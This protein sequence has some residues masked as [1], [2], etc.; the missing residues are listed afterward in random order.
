MNYPPARSLRLDDRRGKEAAKK[1]AETQVFDRRVKNYQ[2]KVHRCWAPEQ[3]SIM[4]N[5]SFQKSNPPFLVQI[6]SECQK[7]RNR[8]GILGRTKVFE[9]TRH[10]DG[11]HRG[12]FSH[13]ILFLILFTILFTHWDCFGV[14]CSVFLGFYVGL[15]HLHDYDYYS[16]RRLTQDICKH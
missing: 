9:V 12:F 1:H 16:R 5:G 11:P 10:S 8:K 3:W 6:S 13:L 2:L 15:T 4:G 7:E 14:R